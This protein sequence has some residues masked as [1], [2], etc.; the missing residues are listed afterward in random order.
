M[1]PFNLYILCLAT[2]GYEG[3]IFRNAALCSL[4]EIYRIFRKRSRSPFSGEKSCN[5]PITKEKVKQSRYR[6]GVA[7][8]V[9]GS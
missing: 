8:R 2:I 7:R 3:N 5:I 4:V 9:P 6:P 1:L